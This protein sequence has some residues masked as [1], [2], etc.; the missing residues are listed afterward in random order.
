[1]LV[2]AE[3]DMAACTTLGHSGKPH[4]PGESPGHPEGGQWVR[5]CYY[6]RVPGS[7]SSR[8]SSVARLSTC[9]SA[10]QHWA[11]LVQRADAGLKRSTVATDAALPICPSLIAKSSSNCTCVGF[12]VARKPARGGPSP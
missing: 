12:A 10:W 7:F 3:L 9:R 11:R 5:R 8:Y 1:M 2:E 4:R 6:R